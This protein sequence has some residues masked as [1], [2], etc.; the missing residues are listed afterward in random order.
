MSELMCIEFDTIAK[1]NNNDY[2]RGLEG[3]QSLRL[4]GAQPLR[5]KRK[6]DALNEGGW[7]GH[8]PSISKYIKNQVFLLKRKLN[9]NLLN[10]EDFPK[11]FY[12]DILGFNNNSLE[13]FKNLG[14]I[15][16]NTRVLIMQYCQFHE[17]YICR[18]LNRYYNQHFNEIELYKPD[19]F[20]VW[21]KLPERFQKKT[22]NNIPTLCRVFIMASYVPILFSNLKIIDFRKF[23]LKEYTAIAQF[24]LYLPIT[25]DLLQLDIDCNYIE[26]FKSKQ[27]KHIEISNNA[28]IF[29]NLIN[30]YNNNVVELTFLFQKCCIFGS[31]SSSIACD[32]LTHIYL[33]CHHGIYKE[34]SRLKFLKEEF[35]KADPCFRNLKL[36]QMKNLE[37]VTLELTPDN[38]CDNI[39][40]NL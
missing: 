40:I 17:I 10:R 16:E 31:L 20:R 35:T 23:T 6:I 30:I 12:L 4:E 29:G 5:T 34:P 25:L 39:I 8:S 3:A 18:R 21:N 33:K 36:E 37:Q 26:L 9:D 14:T 2:S 32:S 28:S 15:D 24:G 22:F 38:L 19:I 7:K 1:L 13:L 11:R 27:I